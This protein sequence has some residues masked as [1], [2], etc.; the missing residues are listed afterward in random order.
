MP[1]PPPRGLGPALSK[2]LVG[3]Y[4]EGVMKNLKGHEMIVFCTW[5]IGKYSNGRS[6]GTQ[7]SS[8]V[9]ALTKHARHRTNGK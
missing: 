6:Y 7:E 2:G 1:N 4:G 5:V 8:A 3:V 9:W